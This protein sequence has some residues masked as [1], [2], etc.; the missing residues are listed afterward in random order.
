MTE[1]VLVLIKPDAVKRNIHFQILQYIC[2]HIQGFNIN[3]LEI[4]TITEKSAEKHY[5]EHKGKFFFERACSL[6]TEGP[7]MKMVIEGDN[8]IQK[9]DTLKRDIRKQFA[10]SESRNCIHVSDSVES[11]E[12]EILLWRIISSNTSHDPFY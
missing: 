11:A 6:L 10:E 2:E 7:L 4:L 9:M 12:R 8:I 1:H 5:E 3:N